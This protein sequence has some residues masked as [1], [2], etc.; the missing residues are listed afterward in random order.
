MKRLPLVLAALALLGLGVG[1]STVLGQ[2]ETTGT[3]TFTNVVTYTIPTVTQ[4]VTVTIA[5]TDTTATAPTTTTT[6]PTCSSQ[7]FCGDYEPGNF[8]QW[9]GHQ[10]TNSDQG[11][12]CAQLGNSAASIVSSPVAQGGDAAK[13]T[14]YSN[15]NGAGGCS[16]S[17]RSEVYTSAANTGG[18]PGE[19]HYYGWWTMLPASDSGRFVTNTSDWNLLTQF[20]GPGSTSGEVVVGVDATS[21]ATSPALYFKVDSGTLKQRIVNP[22][23]WGHWYHFVL[24]VK[25]STSASAGLVQLYVDGSEVVPLTAQQT[26]YN[27]SGA[28]A[29]WKQ[30]L[31][32]ANTGDSTGNIVYHDGACRADT[33][34]DA[35]AC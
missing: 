3:A 26:L 7:P 8:S 6:P 28:S 16:T 5:G 10:W 24:H 22:I 1:V 35:A 9:S 27:V 33:Y 19:E 13:F 18:N 2:G 25:W 32:G 21:S 12:T 31:Y 30:G 17:T 29:Y 4:T 14:V 23:A 20:H 34:A 11:Y 15:N